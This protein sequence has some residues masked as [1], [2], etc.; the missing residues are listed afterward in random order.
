VICWLWDAPAAS[1]T[2]V[3]VPV[4]K[5]VAPAV[6]LAGGNQE[7]FLPPDSGPRRTKIAKAT[8][9]SARNQSTQLQ[10]PAPPQ[11]RSI[12]LENPPLLPPFPTEDNLAVGTPRAHL[13]RSFGKPDLSAR[14]LQQDRL[15]ET[16]VY[17]Q[18][19]QATFIKM[20]DGSVV[21]TYT[22]QPQRVRVLPSEPGPDF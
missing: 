15:V 13:V 12:I 22:G 16:Y 9:D 1:L 19:D 20:Q 14:T 2:P 18:Q 6:H 8:G 21:S 4:R 10:L 11:L 3:E 7:P 5:H 17:K